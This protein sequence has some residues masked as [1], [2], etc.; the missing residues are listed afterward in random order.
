MDLSTLTSLELKSL[1]QRIPKEIERRMKTELADA[2]KALEAMAAERGF[3]L[4][5]LAG[6]APA[7]KER[8]KVAIKYQHPSQPELT[9]TGRGR[10]PRWI[11]AFLKS[12]TLEQL[13]V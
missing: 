10:Q 3:T 9:W 6:A 5:E 7:K 12:G 2:R 13:K 1:L 4:E 11:E 8:A